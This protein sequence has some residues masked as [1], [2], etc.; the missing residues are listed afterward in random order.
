MNGLPLGFDSC[1][2][3]FL[4]LGFGLVLGA[5]LFLL[6]HITSSKGVDSFCNNYE[7][8]NSERRKM[9]SKCFICCYDSAIKDEIIKNQAEKLEKYEKEAMRHEGF[10]ASN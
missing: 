8:S 4:A 2:T 3:A 7:Y 6:E 5:A 10:S 1:F 9:E